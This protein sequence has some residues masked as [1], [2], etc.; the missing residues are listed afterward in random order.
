MSNEPQE[1]DRRDGPNSLEEQLVAY[2]D[3]ELDAKEAAAVE[4]LLANDPEAREA[5][6]RLDRT[7][8]L[9]DRLD[10]ARMDE[11]FAQST[12]EMVAAVAEEDV[13]KWEAGAPA[14]RLRRWAAAAAGLALAALA[15]FLAVAVLRPDPNRRLLDDLA[16]LEDL[17]E[18]R[19]IDDLDFLTML[20]DQEFFA[21]DAGDDT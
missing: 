9:L 17:D 1:T 19:Q 21:R 3:H 6:M 8:S 10:G 20:Y 5:L 11:S 12:L 16:V 15:G 7:W 13:R 2:L 4:Q 14:R 18:L